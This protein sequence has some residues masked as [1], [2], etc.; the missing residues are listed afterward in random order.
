MTQLSWDET[1]E[2]LGCVPLPLL[3]HAQ[4]IKVGWNHSLEELVK[5]LLSHI[6]FPLGSSAKCTLRKQQVPL[7]IICALLSKFLQAMVEHAFGIFLDVTEPQV[8]DHH[9]WKYLF[10]MLAFCNEIASV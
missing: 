7:G 8:V 5:A 10:C 4:T 9:V 2:H 1:H 6:K 3:A